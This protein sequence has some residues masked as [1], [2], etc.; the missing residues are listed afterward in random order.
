MNSDAKLLEELREM[1][2]SAERTLLACRHIIAKIE[3]EEPLASSE[4]FLSERIGSISK[5][6]IASAEGRIIEGVF[7]GQG[8]V[9]GEG[10][11]YPVPAN[12]ASKSKIVVGDKMKLTIT[13]EGKFIYKQIGPVKRKNIV[14][15]LTIDNGQ[16]KVLSN[17]ISYKILQ[18][19]IS[20]HH[21]KVGD[22]VSILVPE[23]GQAEWGA[24]D[25]IIPINSP[26]ESTERK[27]DEDTFF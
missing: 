22:D 7:D 4:R 8:M 11:T 12:Y 10:K 9:D 27:E 13:N 19:S 20:F 15:P 5:N 23:E 26:I 24:F 1:I 17:G 2:T 25:A 14:G 6:Q 21:A 18:A 3:G 16:Y